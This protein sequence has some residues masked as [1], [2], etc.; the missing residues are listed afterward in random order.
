[1][2]AAFDL[3]GHRTA[4]RFGMNSWQ[5][6]WSGMMEVSYVPIF[7]RLAAHN[8]CPSL[9]GPQDWKLGCLFDHHEIFKGLRNH[10][11]QALTGN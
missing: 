5:Q 9:S 4:G 1:M 7:Y 3:I 10:L 2:S 6:S 11:A 8:L